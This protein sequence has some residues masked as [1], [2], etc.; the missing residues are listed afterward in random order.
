[1][2]SRTT[3]HGRGPPS[4]SPGVQGLVGGVPRPVVD[5]APTV[6]SFLHPLECVRTWTRDWGRAGVGDVGLCPRARVDPPEDAVRVDPVRQNPPVPP[7][8]TLREFVC[9]DPDPVVLDEVTRLPASRVQTRA[10]YPLQE[11]VLRL[12][13]TPPSPRV[14][15]SRDMDG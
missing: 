6:C 5:R 8:T 10:A 2:E 3:K 12:P 7:S 15:P 9:K 1:M 4:P 14:C 11:G 13:G